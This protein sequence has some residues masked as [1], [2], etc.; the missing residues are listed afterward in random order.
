[1]S[2]VSFYV[3]DMM[4]QAILITAVELT[5]VEETWTETFDTT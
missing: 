1:M 4:H 5:V 2:A 3:S